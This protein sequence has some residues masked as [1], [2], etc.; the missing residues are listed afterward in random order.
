MWV[1]LPELPPDLDELLTLL[2]LD[3]LGGQGLVESR[4][5]PELRSSRGDAAAGL[6]ALQV[7]AARASV[8]ILDGD[9][10][11]LLLVK[12]IGL[13]DAFLRSDANANELT[14]FGVHDVRGEDGQRKEEEGQRAFPHFDVT[15]R[16]LG[17]DR[18]QPDVGEDRPGR[19]DEE[20]TLVTNTTHFTGWNRHDADGNDHKEIEGS[21]A[22]D[23]ARTELSTL[24]V[25]ADHFDDGEKNLRRRRA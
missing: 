7:G 17:D 15:G 5:S 22:D 6:L 2:E 1:L 12:R 10:Q 11:R 13:R 21:R 18:P 24:E 8:Q 3:L 25:L 9:R 23:R 14:D 16:D 4:P 20:N 19:G